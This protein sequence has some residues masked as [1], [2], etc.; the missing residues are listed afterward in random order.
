MIKTL[1]TWQFAV[2]PHF[3]N[4]RINLVVIIVSLMHK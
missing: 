4:F 2:V 1:I 3:E